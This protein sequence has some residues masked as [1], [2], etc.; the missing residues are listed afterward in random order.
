MSEKGMW[1]LSGSSSCTISHIVTSAVEIVQRLPGD[2]AT[3]L[4]SQYV[5]PSTNKA[6][7]KLLPSNSGYD[8]KVFRLKSQFTGEL[9]FHTLVDISQLNMTAF[10]PIEI[11]QLF[12][13]KLVKM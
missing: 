2:D 10:F 5:I 9:E 4:D 7:F 8:L 3:E 13:G 1:G 12:T 6:L 11:R